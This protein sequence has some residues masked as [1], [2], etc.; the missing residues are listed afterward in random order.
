MAYTATE[1]AALLRVGAQGCHSDEAAVGLLV[2]HDTW[3]NRSDFIRTCVTV[4]TDSFVQGEQVAAFIDWSNAVRVLD[5]GGLPCSRGEAAVLRIAAGLAG[6]PVNLRAML[7]G[8]DSRN[9]QLVAEAVMHANGTPIASRLGSYA[10]GAQPPSTMPD[11]PPI[12]Q[13]QEG[14]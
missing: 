8:L 2:E 10:S 11:V 7:G 4:Q 12:T 9:I 5:A 6:V 1:L 14:R 13:Q 3:L